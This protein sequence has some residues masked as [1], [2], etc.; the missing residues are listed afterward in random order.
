[1]SQQLIYG[2]HALQ[3][4]LEQQPQLLCELYLDQQRNDARCQTLLNLAKA[5]QIPCHRRTRQQLTALAKT[6]THQG[7][8]GF[9][10]LLPPLQE[11]EFFH[12]LAQTPQA[13]VVMLDGIQDPHN[14]GACL[15]SAAALGATAMVIPR[16]NAA[17]INATVRKVASG[18]DQ[19]LPLLVTSNMVNL[20][21]KMKTQ[22]HWI[23][24]TTLEQ[25]SPLPQLGLTGAITLVMGAEQK[26]LR[27]LVR[28]N[29][30]FL[31]KIP[32]NG[33]ITSLNVSVATGICLYE[34]WRQR[35][36]S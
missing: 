2:Q 17:P 22:G 18:A 35:N 8:V 23:V 12:L 25:A 21:K 15:R 7:V 34:I 32:L 24:G 5:H 10:K 20:I 11:S 9:I 26:G 1:M 33:P 16:H 13:V 19:V 3:I 30:D 27:P 31:A 28:Q 4:A 29:C 14:L 6:D 36:S